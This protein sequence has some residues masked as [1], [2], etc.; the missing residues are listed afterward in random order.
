MYSTAQCICK[1]YENLMVSAQGAC[2]LAVLGP[3][4][5]EHKIP[6]ITS[7]VLNHIKLLCRHDICSFQLMDKSK[8]VH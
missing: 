8:D 2:T 5:P 6:K 3:M 4:Q 7:T 1:I